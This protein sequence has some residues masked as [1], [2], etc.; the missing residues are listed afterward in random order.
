M[1]F[2]TFYTWFSELEVSRVEE[3][4]A[5]KY[6]YCHQFSF[7][8]SFIF[9]HVVIR[10]YDHSVVFSYGHKVT[11]DTIRWSSDHVVMRSYG[12]TG[13]V[14]QFIRLNGHKV[15]CGSHGL[16]NCHC[17]TVTNFMTPLVYLEN[18]HWFHLQWFAGRQG[19]TIPKNI[20]NYRVYQETGKR[21][22]RHRFIQINL[23]NVVQP[24]HPKNAAQQH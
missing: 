17:L 1:M 14:Y 16:F 7:R 9:V 22:L 8:G 13:N 15:Q 21:D 12:Q 11:Q 20:R 2:Y 10:S 24:F 6:I 19:L 4:P 23:F 5:P 18:L 3:E